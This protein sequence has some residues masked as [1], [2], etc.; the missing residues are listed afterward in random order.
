MNFNEISNGIH[1]DSNSIQTRWASLNTATLKFS[2]IYHAR[3]RSPPSAWQRLKD[4]PKWKQPPEVK[5]DN[6]KEKLD[7]MNDNK[8]EPV[9]VK[10]AKRLKIEHEKDLKELQRS[11]Q[12]A[13]KKNKIDENM[14]NIMAQETDSQT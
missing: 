9:G 10:I 3:E 6:Q 11:S 12:I 13:Q 2:A 7:M 4:A 1:C 8:E 5:G 14:N